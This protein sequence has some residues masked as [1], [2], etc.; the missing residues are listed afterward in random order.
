LF[1]GLRG[2]GRATTLDGRLWVAAERVPMLEA[3]FPGGGCEPAVAVPERDRAKVWTREDAIRELVRGRLEVI[4]PT[5]AAEIAKVLGLPGG[6]VDIALAALEH[7]GFALRG[8]FSS[9]VQGT[10]WCAG[11]LVVR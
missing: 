11:R 6:D 7:E 5:T 9:G 1:E 8:R 4:G 10:E 2:A 3:A